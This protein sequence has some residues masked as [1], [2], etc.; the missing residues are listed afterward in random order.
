VTHF[1][2]EASSFVRTLKFVPTDHGVE[3]VVRFAELAVTTCS[4]TCRD[5]V[6]LAACEL[7]EN[8]AKYGVASPDPRAGTLSVDSQ[9]NVIRVSV[10]NAVASREDALRVTALVTR[11]AASPSVADLYRERLQQLFAD[12]SAP[13]TQLGLLRLAFEGGFRLSASFQAPLLQVVA[14]RPCESD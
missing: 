6:T 1:H 12:S 14:E 5:A 10:T 13:R 9:R 4:R 7:A 11:I 8:A 2:G 3:D